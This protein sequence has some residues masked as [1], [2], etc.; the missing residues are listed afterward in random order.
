[1][2]IQNLLSLVDKADLSVIDRKPFSFDIRS[3]LAPTVF[4]ACAVIISYN[5]CQNRWFKGRLDGY[6]SLSRFDST[7]NGVPQP[8]KEDKNCFQNDLKICYC[9]RF[10]DECF[11]NGGQKKIKMQ[12]YRRVVNPV[13][14][15]RLSTINDCKIKLATI[16]DRVELENSSLSHFIFSFLFLKRNMIW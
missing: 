8:Q 6:S 10:C 13:W 14:N 9:T 1:M 2:N 3:P 11:F 7:Q 5:C 16:L 4:T 15:V 12:F